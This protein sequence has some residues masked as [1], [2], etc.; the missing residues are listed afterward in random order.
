MGC[1][2]SSAS[3]RRRRRSSGFATRM[4]RVNARSK[5]VRSYLPACCR[6]SPTPPNSSHS[7]EHCTG[8]FVS[9]LVPNLKGAAACA[10][11]GRGPDAGSAVGKPRAQ[12]RQPARN[13]L[14]TSSP[15]LRRSVPRAMPAGSACLIEVGISTAFGCTIQGRVDPA[16]VLRLLQAALDA[17][18]D[19]VGL[20]DT[21]GYADP[22]MVSR[23]F[24]QA[25]RIA[26]DQLACGHFHDTRGLGM[27]NVFAAWQAG[28]RRFDA[29]AGR[30]RRVPACARRERQR[31]D[32]RRRLPVR[33]HGR[34][35]PGSTSTS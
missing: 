33:E 14:T 20:A 8:L 29:Y 7:P 23:L 13:R 21:V 31:R 22:L 25:A 27:A 34:F 24:E 5:S 11:V 16:E 19:R 15:R 10:R 28:I 26:G 35:R 9:V 30:H 3:C 2:A 17:G 32:R 6:N 4:P 1:R 12:P 18:A